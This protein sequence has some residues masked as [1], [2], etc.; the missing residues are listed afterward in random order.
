[1]EG[2]AGHRDRLAGRLAALGQGDVEQR[3]GTPRVV[4]EQLVEV[5][6]AIEHQPIRVLGL[7]APGTGASFADVPA[8]VSRRVDN[9]ELRV[10]AAIRYRPF[11][12]VI[13]ISEAVANA[14][15][16]VGVEDERIEVIR[17]AV[18]VAPFD[19]HYARATIDEAFGIEP[20][21]FAIVAAGQLI[22]R[23][24]HKLLLEAVAALSATQARFKLVIFGEGELED[25]LKRQTEALGLGRIVSF[26]GYREDLDELIG[27]FDLLVHPAL[28]EGLGVVTLKAAAAGLPVVG[29]RAG[30]LPESVIDGETGM[31]LPAGDVAALTGAIA[32]LMNDDERR[33]RYGAN[34]K[35]RMQAEFSPA[36][37]VDKHIALY[38]AVLND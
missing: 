30:G 9:T 27:C 5:A 16:A 31:L 23:K 29:F 35:A 7:D 13:A 2:H 11:Q 18:D 38:E 24:G 12:R 21:E 14:L 33:A 6:H 3:G 10:L 34:G 4:V 22:E 15:R 1:V 26:A 36:Q 17:S 25:D 8:V 28:T 20:E 37:M 32:T 19:R